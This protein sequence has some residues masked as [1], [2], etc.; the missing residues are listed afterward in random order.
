[1]TSDAGADTV[2]ILGDAPHIRAISRE[3]EATVFAAVVEANLKQP[4]AYAGRILDDVMQE[5]A[6]GLAPLTGATA[7]EYAT[8]ITQ[9]ITVDPTR[10][11][12]VG[13]VFYAG[14]SIV[15]NIAHVC[16][17]GDI[18]VH[19]VRNG[20]VV[21][22]TRDHNAVSD[23]EDGTYNRAGRGVASDPTFLVHVP[24]RSLP[25]SESKPIE[26]AEWPTLGGDT[27]LICSSRLHG[28]QPPA[29]YLAPLVQSRVVPELSLAV[30]ISIAPS[31]VPPPASRF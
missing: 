20:A 2:V 5:A 25:A 27:L 4:E 12:N 21:G 13:A 29:A 1:M 22:V 10:W 30:L 6:R 19:L 3:D 15:G 11:R 26:C 18:R 23:D 17:A 14:V 9:A 28:Y 8:L 16:T 7:R 24:T 31:R